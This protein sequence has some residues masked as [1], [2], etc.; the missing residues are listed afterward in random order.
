MRLS[1]FPMPVLEI[2]QIAKVAMHHGSVYALA[3]G[4]DETTFLSGGS[5][6]VV[7]AW[8]LLQPDRA[9]AL[10][11]VDGQIFALLLLPGKNHL[12]I[13]TMSGGLHMV[14]LNLKKE[15]HYIT[16][17]EQSI[18]DLKLHDQKL[19]VAS[20][21]GSLSVWSAETYELERVVQVSDMS[22]RM[23]DFNPVNQ[24]AAIA[25][26]DNNSYLLDLQQWKIKSVLQG[27][28]NSV[29]SVCYSLNGERLLAGSRDAQLYIYDLQQNNLAMQIKA[30]LY[31]I[32]HIQFIAG[33]RFF[34]TASRD[35]TIRIWDAKTFDLVK[36]I[37][38]TKNNG[39]I[40]SVNRLLWMESFGNL[41]S[42]S[43]DR[44]IIIWKIAH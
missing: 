10:A 14:D 26:S 20:K 18:F 8:N 9:I 43:D 24:E 12:V 2:E 5:E 29:F 1:L 39:H 19:F 16:Y 6:G 22:L 3:K 17:H 27:P 23:I 36:S 15:I 32:N 21:D 7:I 25:C 33:G 34:A 41:I 30:H 38:K 40:N 31:T 28:D 11:K 44:S 4:Y 37:D 13:G 42:A 35:K